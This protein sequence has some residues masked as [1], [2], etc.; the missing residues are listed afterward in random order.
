MSETKRSRE[1]AS[2]EFKPPP[3]LISVSVG[4]GPFV[5]I[6]LDEAIELHLLLGHAIEQ[7][8]EFNRRAEGS[9]APRL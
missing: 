3:P 1:K 9:D 5:K 4:W 6:P 2:A 7:A 8:K